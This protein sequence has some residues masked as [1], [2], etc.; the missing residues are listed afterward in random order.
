MMMTMMV[1]TAAKKTN[2]PKTPK[3]MMPPMFS[4]AKGGMLGDR[5]CDLEMPLPSTPGISFKC[6]DSYGLVGLLVDLLVCFVF[7]EW[8]GLME[9]IVL[10]V[11][12]GT[13]EEDEVDTETPPLS[14]PR[15][16]GFVLAPLETLEVADV[17]RSAMLGR[18]VT[19]TLETSGGDVPLQMLPLGA[20]LR[21]YANWNVV[22]AFVVVGAEVDGLVLVVLGVL[23][24]V[25]VGGDGVAISANGLQNT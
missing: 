17:G 19:V 20:L 3:A 1:M 8:L 11:L 9:V 25:V 18:L 4:R 16:Y 5:A 10:G 2:P 12:F 14:P 7:C 23:V 21:L 6:G 24:V 13:K 22:G 15:V